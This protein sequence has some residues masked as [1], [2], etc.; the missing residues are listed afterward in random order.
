M[1]TGVYTRTPG[2][3]KGPPLIP[4]EER[5]WAKVDKNGPL[6]NGTPCWLWL[7]AKYS[8]GYGRFKV[9]ARLEAVRAHR[10]AYE[11]LV[12]PIPEGLEIDHLCRNPPCVKPAH[13][14]AVTHSTN[15]KRGL[16]GQL[17]THCNRGHEFN[18]LNT[19]ISPAGGRQCRPC[20][21]YRAALKRAI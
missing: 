20:V 21:N 9:N 4:P 1:P 7:A 15:V 13:L 17:Q 12:G 5:F 3:T 11:Q 10:W 16:R 14:E 2:Q 19:Y 6:W 8:L 18:S